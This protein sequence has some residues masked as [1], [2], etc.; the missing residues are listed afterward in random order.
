MQW[1]RRFDEC[2]A[3]GA[4]TAEAPTDDGDLDICSRWEK[5]QSGEGAPPELAPLLAMMGQ[6]MDKDCEDMSPEEKATFE[7]MLNMML[8]Q[9]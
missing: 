8:S 6:G 3:E 2:G 4:E 9:E 7:Q 1:W 5:L